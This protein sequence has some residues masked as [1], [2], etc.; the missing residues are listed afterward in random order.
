MFNEDD[1]QDPSVTPRNE[2]GDSGSAACPDEAAPPSSSD[3]PPS[4]AGKAVSP[5]KLAANRQNA[6][7]STGPRTTEGKQKSSMNAFKHGIFAGRLFVVGKLWAEDGQDYTNL[8]SGMRDHY[9]PQGC[10]E[11][12][13]LERMVTEAVRL[14][15]IIGHETKAMQSANYPF[16]SAYLDR[17]NRYQT[18]VSKQ[19]LQAQK[20]L[21]RLQAVRKA[22]SG[23]PERFE[24][25][26]EAGD[27]FSEQGSESVLYHPPEP[28]R[29]PSNAGTNP[30]SQSSTQHQA[31]VSIRAV[32]KP[33]YTLAQLTEK[34]AGLEPAKEPHATQTENAETK[35]TKT[36]AE[37]LTEMYFP[38][39]EFDEFE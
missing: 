29:A 10:M 36:T 38:R 2:A 14:A 17:V 12:F 7:R 18:T 20:E 21:E 34:A 4:H 39:K 5:R 24:N 32:T 8:A 26:P 30:N 1:S 33:R 3:G 22:T 37:Q 11:E 9:Q 6:Q 19:L 23:Q 35:P 13:W 25:D 16:H 27:T 31:P 28:M 15:R